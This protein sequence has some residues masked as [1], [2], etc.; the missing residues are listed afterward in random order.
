MSNSRVTHARH[1]TQLLGGAGM[2]ILLLIAWLL[3]AAYG[4]KFKSVE[5]ITVL[6]DRSGLLLDKGT[7]VRLSGVPVGEVRGTSVTPDGKVSVDVALDKGEVGKIPSNVSAAIHG[8][9]VFGSKFVDLE[10]PSSGAAAT[11][12]SG[13]TVLDARGVTVEA[14]DVFQNAIK[15]MKAVRPT[16]LNATLTSVATALNGRGRKFG[17]FFTDWNRYLRQVDPH[18]PGLEGDLALATSVTTS[19]ADAAPALIDAADNFSTT[20]DTLLSQRAQLEALFPAIDNAARSAGVFLNATEA[21]L[22]S[23]LNEWAPVSSVLK[24]YSPEYDCLF[25][26]LRRNVVV[27]NRVFG[28]QNP[29]E[30]FFYGDTGFLPGQEPYSFAKNAPKYV[31]GLGPHCYPTAAADPTPPHY[32]FDD[33]TAGVYSEAATGKPVQLSQLPVSIYGEVVQQW[34]GQ[35]GAGALLGATSKGASK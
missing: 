9:T 31:T 27:F 25:S 23:F 6:S 5:H 13:G 22:G 16:D 8:T 14:N 3:V 12:I 17:E 32:N 11:P 30:H 10:V 18:L 15:V 19:Y 34:L 21:P 33:G 1:H 24:E 29:D 2:A 4:E 26:S 20:A 28:L 35:S 7:R